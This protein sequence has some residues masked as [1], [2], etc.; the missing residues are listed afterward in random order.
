MQKIQL[1]LGTP[2]LLGWPLALPD[3]LFS[4]HL[5]NLVRD[6]L[7]GP[8]KGKKKILLCTSEC[9]V[10]NAEKKEAKA[11]EKKT[12]VVEAK[13]QRNVAKVAKSEAVEQRRHDCE[14]QSCQGPH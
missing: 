8:A 4:E 7:R 5:M 10:T 3:V 14:K 12:Q 13:A 2:S 9:I 11:R 1:R 6:V